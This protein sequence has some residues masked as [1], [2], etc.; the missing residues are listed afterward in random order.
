MNTSNWNNFLKENFENNSE[1]IMESTDSEDVK[2]VI[3]TAIRPV[4]SSFI[5]LLIDKNNLNRIIRV[6]F[7]SN[8]SNMLSLGLI[9]SQKDLDIKFVQ[10]SWFENDK[11]SYEI[12]FTSDNAS[13]LLRLLQLPLKH[14]WKETHYFHRNKLYKVD[15]NYKVNNVF[16]RYE[17]VIKS[18][19]EQD[20]P[21]PFDSLFK[22]LTKFLIE[23]IPFYRN[24]IIQKE[25]SVDPILE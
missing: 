9:N 6:E 7:G 15:I 10:D 13:K 18:F 3:V 22:K 1:Y 21:L 2:S 5:H 25:Y 17:L 20:I 19:E 11:K 12:Y 4:N 14:G 16:K 24:K 23:T 8:E